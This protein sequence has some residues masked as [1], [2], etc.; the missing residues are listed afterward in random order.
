M[1]L[2]GYERGEAAATF[3]LM[4]RIELDR[5]HGAGQGARRHRR[6]GHPPAPGPVPHARSRSCATSACARSRSS[7][8][9]TSPGPESGIF[10]LYWSEYHQEVTQLAVDILGADAMAPSGRWPTSSFQTDSPGAP[11]DSAS[12]VGTSYNAR[13]GTI[14]AGSSQIQR[15]I[16]GEMVLGLPKEPRRRRPA[17][18]GATSRRPDPEPSGGRARAVRG[19]A[20]APVAV[21]HCGSAR[22][23]GWRAPG[24]W[25]RPPFLPLP[26]PTTS[27]SGWRP[28]TAA[29]GDQPP[30]PDDLVTYLR[31]CR[32][33]PSPDPASPVTF[34]RCRGPSCSTPPTS[35][36]AWCRA[37]APRCSC[38]GTRPTS[39]TTPARRC[40]PSTSRSPVPSVIRLRH[41]VKVPFRRRA[42]L[43]RRGRVR[44]GR[45]PV[46]VLRRTPPRASTTSCP[47]AGAASTRGRTWSRRAGPAT[48]ASAT[49]SSTRPRWCCAADP[50][51]PAR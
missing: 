2:L 14:Y 17:D 33:W 34:R 26:A 13:A 6:P 9:A 25:R 24:W 50:T 30:E 1:T 42:P 32:N 11:N 15:N 35:R 38:S 8:T 10:K 46:P 7:S 29:P 39:S 43:N 16:I 49:G 12:W 37:G 36:C 40:T 47:A 20:A 51:R 27:G 44:P 48:C 4:F 19:G 22:P 41:F 23:V 45:P 3:P 5:L 28:R 21:A 18:A 31:W